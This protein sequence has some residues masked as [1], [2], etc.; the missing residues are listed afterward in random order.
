MDNVNDKLFKLY[1]KQ[2]CSLCEALDNLSVDGME[3]YEKNPL[4]LRIDDSQEYE[5]ADLKIMMFGQDMSLG[6]WYKYNRHTTL[7]NCMKNIK[8]FRNSIG[9]VDINT[10]KRQSRGFGGGVNKFID[11]L[12][13][14]M[15]GCEIQF[16]WNDLAKIGRNIKGNPNR[17]KLEEI[18]NN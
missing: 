12:R 8:T 15:P 7:E 17:E 2:W 4:L 11:I 9:S 1:S 10:Q 3:D 5:K 18:E 13:K 14:K 16:V 6:D